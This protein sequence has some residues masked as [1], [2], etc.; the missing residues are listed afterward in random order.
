M[1]PD[2]HE[3]GQRL[4]EGEVDL[5]L[6]SA[7][8]LMGISPKTPQEVVCD[9][10]QID[11]VGKSHLVYSIWLIYSLGMQ[12]ISY[13]VWWRVLITSIDYHSMQWHRYAI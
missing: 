2:C 12:V 10:F 7:Y 4:K 13:F 9:Y 8:G 5:S 3:Q 6:K 1:P 11:F